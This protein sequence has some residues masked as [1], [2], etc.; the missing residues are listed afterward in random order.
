MILDGGEL[1]WGDAVVVKEEARREM[2]LIRCDKLTRV[3]QG[4]V[5]EIRPLDE[6]D[7]A[8]DREQFGLM[9]PS[10]SGKT[11]LLNL[12]AGIDR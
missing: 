1:D 10:G 2:T 9:G 12:L 7:L 4:G 5:E 8:I 11:T 3:Y 6:L